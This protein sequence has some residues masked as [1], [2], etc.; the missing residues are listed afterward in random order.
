MDL[1]MFGE[2]Y[3]GYTVPTV[4]HPTGR[5]NFTIVRTN[6]ARYAYSYETLIGFAGYGEI[7]GKWK[8]RQNEWGP[9]TGKHLNLLKDPG[10]Y[11][12]L[13]GHDFLHALEAFQ[14]YLSGDPIEGNPR[15]L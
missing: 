11:Q 9:T 10:H 1:N 8:L 14:R 15:T 4:E 5:P 7:L 6:R 13:N 2:T 3:S 12:T